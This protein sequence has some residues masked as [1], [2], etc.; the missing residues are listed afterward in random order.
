MDRR[1][2]IFLYAAFF[3]PMFAYASTERKVV[4]VHTDVL[5]S[6]VAE[7]LEATASPTPSKPSSASIK[8]INGKIRISWN[9]AFGATSYK[10]EL[11]KGKDCGEIV[12]TRTTSNVEFLEFDPPSS[13]DYAARVS[14]CSTQCS[15]PTTTSW[16]NVFIFGPSD[17]I[18]LP[19]TTG[20]CTF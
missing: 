19:P 20:A 14:A 15:S 10:V 11:L 5:G 8:Y 4:F 9:S 3:L 13:G 17:T 18:G 1:M 6:P 12:N 2:K 16:A 7:S